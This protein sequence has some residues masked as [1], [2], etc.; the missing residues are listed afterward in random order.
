MIL[1]RHRGKT[2]AAYPAVTYGVSVVRLSDSLALDFDDMEF[3]ED[4]HVQVRSLLAEVAGVPGVWH[5]QVELPPD[6][7]EAVQVVVLEGPGWTAIRDYEVLVSDGEARTHV[8]AQMTAL[9]TNTGGVGALQFVD[10]D[11]NPVADADVRVFL[12]SDYA[13]DPETAQPLAMTTTDDDGNFRDSIYLEPAAVYTI[14]YQK[15]GVL[16]PVTQDI[17]L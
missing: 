11:G 2:V 6:L 16:G 9:H 8:A 1:V 4:G 15:V 12:A 5:A 10:A 13:S 7:D 3:K 17:S 14:H